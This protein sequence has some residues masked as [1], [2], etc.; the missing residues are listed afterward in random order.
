MDLRLQARWNAFW[1]PPSSGRGEA[2]LRV[3][4]A[5]VLGLELIGL[6]GDLDLY[7]VS[8]GAHPPTIFEA[9]Y[10]RIMV[11]ALHAIWCVVAALLLIGVWTRA[12]TIVNLVLAIYFFGLRGHAAPHGADWLIHSMAFCL[13]FMQSDRWLSLSSRR[14]QAGEP[15]RVRGWPLRLA[16]LSYASLYFTAGLAKLP[17]P[18]WRDGTA[19]ASALLNPLVTRFDF[20]W[21]ARYPGLTSAAGYF[22]LIWELAFPFLL[23]S[24]R[25][26]AWAVASAIAFHLGID[27]VLR[28]GWF[29]WFSIA[30]A[31]VFYDDVAARFRR[32]PAAARPS[33]APSRRAQAFLLFH[34]C[35]FVAAQAA[36][37]AAPIAGKSPFHMP[38]LRVPGLSEYV[39]YVARI[40]YFNVFPS[41]YILEPVRLIT[42]EA[43]DE[44]GRPRALA[45]FDEAG[46]FRPGLGMS[47]EVREGLLAL[48]IVAY[49]MP[50]PAWERYAEHLAKR[51]SAQHEGCP[52]QIAFYRILEPL[53]AFGPDPKALEVPRRALV[54][55]HFRCSERRLLRLEFH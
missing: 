33:S 18:A 39:A 13:V 31:A 48:R 1:S 30:H 24:R 45:P 25:T 10:A 29:G 16:Q 14:K 55:A 32:Q 5:S 47:R 11:H 9:L 27:W 23:V 41:S 26:R 4:Y 7:F 53:S 46:A 12:V 43:R 2:L 50:A 36:Y 52:R 20:T 6:R 35:A 22:V 37:L 19:F 51:Y 15:D 34:A 42:Y 28:V 17:D 21:T 8:G 3:G 44:R 49:G 54:T 40:Q 38:W